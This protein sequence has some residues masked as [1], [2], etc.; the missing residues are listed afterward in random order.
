[1]FNWSIMPSHWKTLSF[2][3]AASVF[4]SG[5]CET[6]QTIARGQDV[7]LIPSEISL[8]GLGA[9][10]RILV[11]T[12]YGSRRTGQVDSTIIWSIDDPKVVEFDGQNIQAV[13]NG[14][15]MLRAFVNGKELK[16]KV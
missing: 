9:K 12:A 14:T 7:E 16:A 3:I 15:T 13:G 11:E 2:L 5:I 10:S 4:G 1:M 8:T 6:G